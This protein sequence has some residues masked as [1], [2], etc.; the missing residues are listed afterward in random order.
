MPDTNACQPT[1][2]EPTAWSFDN[3]FFEMPRIT[4]PKK[5]QGRPKLKY[6]DAKRMY[7]ASEWNIGNKK[8]HFNCK[9]DV[10]VGASIKANIRSMT[11]S[12]L[13]KLVWK[14]DLVNELLQGNLE[15]ENMDMKLHP[16]DFFKFIKTFCLLLEKP[17]PKESECW[18]NEKLPLARDP[19]YFFK[20][21]FSIVGSVVEQLNRN[22]QLLLEDVGETICMDEILE[23]FRGKS[24]AKKYMARK[25]GGQGHLVWEMCVFL[26]KSQ[27]TICIGMMPWLG[28]PTSTEEVVSFFLEGLNPVYDPLIVMDAY[29]LNLQLYDYLVDNK[30]G[31]LCSVSSIRWEYL[32]KIL[33]RDFCK[34]LDDWG[35]MENENHSTFA[36]SYVGKKKNNE[37][38]Y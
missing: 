5:K 28:Q 6:S 7:D 25:P 31:F 1:K 11:V 20:R 12:E 16:D 3:I 27:R 37:C 14:G 10:S 24:A 36:I 23:K 22:L 2:F 19:Y 15:E 33:H 4:T 30:W 34:Q 32:W 35:W 21:E 18:S 29:F 13:F 9:F 8:V 26:K 38:D 17:E